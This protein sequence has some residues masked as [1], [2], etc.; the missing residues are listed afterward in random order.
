MTLLTQKNRSVLPSVVSDFFNADRFLGPSL[1]DFNSSLFDNGM[2]LFS[3]DANIVEGE[4][5]F[6]IELAAPG[7]ERKDFKIELDGGLLTISSEKKEEK[8]ESQKNFLRKEFS[9]SSF[10]RNFT[11]PE[12]SVSDK[13]EA[14]YESGILNVII[15]KKE[16]TLSKPK[17]E[18]KVL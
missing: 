11:L 1:L 7:L 18:I 10:S 4:K 13:I 3:P 14:K 16:V 9:Y 17:K 8:E 15:P 5:D 12:N 6:K 2:V